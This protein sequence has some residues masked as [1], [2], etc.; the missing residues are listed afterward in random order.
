[1]SEYLTNRTDTLVIR[2]VLYAIEPNSD[3]RRVV[4]KNRIMELRDWTSVKAPE[5]FS[6]SRFSIWFA[7]NCSGYWQYPIGHTFW[8]SEE[9]DVIKYYFNYHEL[10]RSS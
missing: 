10:S 1:M 7:D 5:D 4:E 3:D 6:Y 9:E 2:G 8:F